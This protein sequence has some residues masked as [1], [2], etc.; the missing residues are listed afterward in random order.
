MIEGGVL[1]ARS[2]VAVLARGGQV[3]GPMIRIRG[4]G[5]ILEMAAGAG[6]RRAGELAA[7]MALNAGDGCMQ[8]GQRKCG[9]LVV[10]EGRARP[11]QS[12]VTEGA[13]LRK[14]RGDVVGILRRNEIVRMAA[15]AGGRRAGEP[16]AHMALGAGDGG[17]RASEREVRKLLMIKARALPDVHAVA[18]LAGGRQ[19]GRNMVQRRGRLVIPQV[20]GNAL[21]AQPDVD[22]RGGPA[23]AIITGRCRVRAD[24][25]KPVVVIA[26]GGDLDVPAAHRVALLAV[27]PEL[28]PVQIRVAIRAAG[29]RL[30]KHQVHM[31]SCARHVLMQPEQR[32]FCLGVV[33]KLGLFPDRLPRGRRMAVF[34]S[35]GQRAV[36]ICNPSA[37]AVLCED[38]RRG[39]H[40]Y[41]EQ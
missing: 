33:I 41:Q 9:Q 5:V 35:D 22:A 36:R 27:R 4:V 1:P 24:E 12:C 6:C 23:M 34:A 8:A 29:R 30:R 11:C 21:G 37:D 17:V 31:A 28:A 32:E 3:P 16:V 13:I 7:H 40:V 26:N 18:V 39:R 25:G 15:V 14:R 10:I 19:P 2:I 38:R 20:A